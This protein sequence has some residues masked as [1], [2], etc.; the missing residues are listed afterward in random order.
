VLV[1]ERKISPLSAQQLTIYCPNG[2]LIAIHLVEVTGSDRARIGIEAPRPYQVCR[3]DAGDK[4][5]S[6]HTELRH[7]QDT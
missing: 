6:S 3:A 7:A 5:P 2:D 1:L 4:C